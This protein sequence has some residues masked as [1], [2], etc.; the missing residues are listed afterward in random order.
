MRQLDIQYRE[1]EIN[2][3]RTRGRGGVRIDLRMSYGREMRDPVFREMWRRPTNSY[4]LGVNGQIPIWDWGER[5]SRIA[6]SEINLRQ[7][8]LRREETAA[9]IRASVQSEIRSVA[10]YQS[11]ALAMEENLELATTLSGQSLARYRAGELSALELLQAF[12]RESDTAENLLDAYLGWRR[13]IS[14]LQ[15]LTF[16]DFE[17]DMP[18]LDRFG[19]EARPGR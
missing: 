10:E 16:Y 15:Q 4:T 9:S 17:Y 12:R 7:T 11:R 14:E 1:N 5:R 13:A 19:L 18:L 3:D 2:L 8:E 6:A